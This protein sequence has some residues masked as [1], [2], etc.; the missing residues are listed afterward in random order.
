MGS[1]E[2]SISPSAQ[3]EIEALKSIYTE[4]E[5]KSVSET[6]NRFE[7]TDAATSQP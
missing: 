1:L 6:N 3:E 2:P 7:V 4:E 5:F